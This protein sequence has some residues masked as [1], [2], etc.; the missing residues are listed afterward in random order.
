M[1]ALRPLHGL[2]YDLARTGP[3]SALLA[4]PYDVI[5]GDGRA[6]LAARSPDNCVHVILPEGDG[7]ARYA[8]GAAEFRRLEQTAFV[9]DPSP[10][11][12]VL[13]Q[14]FEALGATHVRKG[15]VA[16]IELTRFGEGPVLPHERTLAGPK[17]DRLQLMRACE[18]HV[19]LVFGLFADPRCA[20]E[21]AVAPA[22]GEPVLEA[23]LDGVGHTL[24]RVDD[25]AAIARVAALLADKSVYMADGHH[26]YETMCAFADELVARGWGDDARYGLVFLGNL[27]DPG[28]VVLPTHRVVHHVEPERVAAA[29]AELPRW[30]DVRELPLPG[31]AEGVRALL[32]EASAVRPSLAFAVPG[33][34]QLQLAT[35]RADFDPAVAGLGAIAPALQRLD[36]VL[37]HELV[38]EAGLGID[39]LAQAAK[40]NLAYLKS[41]DV[42]LDVA[43]SGVLPE[44]AGVTAQLVAFAH[45]TA[46]QDVVAVCDSGEVMPQKSTFFYPK[47]PTGLVFHDLRP[48]SAA[49]DR[50]P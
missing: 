11:V 43:R 30:F 33:T 25:A 7:D 1:V 14:R 10:S 21:A 18:A 39:K 40:T 19:E 35:L 9:R 17:L 5:D 15:L 41:T 42:A 13:H 31:A 20:W 37:L 29:L 16:R 38:L 36:L 26:R 49:G 44:P 22:L 47:I 23:E 46:V 12:Y 45:P 34:G 48:A 4:P 28:L 6:A 2:R 24:Y 3:A 27:D 8:R 32:A 50:R